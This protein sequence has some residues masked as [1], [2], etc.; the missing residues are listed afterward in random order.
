VSRAYRPWDIGHLLFMT[1]IVAF[2]LIAIV[3]L[4][5]CASAVKPPESQFFSEHSPATAVAMPSPAPL[6]AR[7]SA[8]LAATPGGEAMLF[9]PSAALQLLLRDEIGEANTRIAAECSAGYA[10]L[11]GAYDVLLEHA[12]AL[13]QRYNLLGSHWAEAETELQRQDTAHAAENWFNRLLLLLAALGLA[14]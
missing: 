12:Q 9:E 6:P 13:E 8:E 5:G 3:A 11:S 14:L 7:P 10:E 1:L 4:A 2:L